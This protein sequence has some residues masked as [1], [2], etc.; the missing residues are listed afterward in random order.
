VESVSSDPRLKGRAEVGR[1]VAPLTPPSSLPET[2]LRPE[3]LL[4]AS[5]QQLHKDQQRLLKS[6]EHLVASL[7]H[8]RRTVLV[9]QL[10][11]GLAGEDRV[12]RAEGGA[13]EL[14]ELTLI[15]PTTLTD[16]GVGLF[17]DDEKV[18]DYVKFSRLNTISGYVQLLT[19]ETRPEGNAVTFQD[20]KFTRSVEVRVRLPAAVA[21]PVVSAQLEVEGGVVVTPT[22][23]PIA[24]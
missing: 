24:L 8:R 7:D 5:Q 15:A 4:I 12:L 9:E 3:L 13:G 1:D 22:P 18:L 11:R 23:G 21:F 14:I 19:A 6:L 20:V 17:I 10:N 16:F 2:T